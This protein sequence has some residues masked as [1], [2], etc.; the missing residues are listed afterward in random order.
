M[1]NLKHNSKKSI[2][3]QHAEISA[4]QLCEFSKTDPVYKDACE[5]A[6]EILREERG[7]TNTQL[8]LFA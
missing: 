7:R 4:M 5:V 3:L 2:R 1:K 8:N 6:M